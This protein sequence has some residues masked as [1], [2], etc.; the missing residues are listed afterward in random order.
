METTTQDVQNHA[1]HFM[2]SQMLLETLLH[3][4]SPSNNSHK[5]LFEEARRLYINNQ[6]SLDVITEFERDYQAEDHIK[7]HT[8][9]SFLYRLVNKALR[10]Q[11]ICLIFKFRFLIQHIHRQLKNKQEKNSAGMCFPEIETGLLSLGLVSP[12]Q[13]LDPCSLP[14]AACVIIYMLIL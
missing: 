2:R 9:D 14:V 13:A 7:W 12:R 11:D 6:F 10:T 3:V 8:R 4:P 5:D 1:A